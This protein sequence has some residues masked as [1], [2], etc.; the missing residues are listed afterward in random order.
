MSWKLVIAVILALQVTVS[1]CDLPQPDQELVAKYGNVM[2]S[3]HKRL[4]PYFSMIRDFITAP[5][6]EHVLYSEVSLDFF[7]KLS[8]VP[9]IQSVEKVTK[10]VAREVSSL[11]DK[12]RMAAL[13]LY[14]EH[15]RPWA[16][17]YVDRAIAA[18]ISFLDTLR[19]HTNWTL[20]NLPLS[21]IIRL[22]HRPLHFTLGI[23][24]IHNLKEMSGKLVI[25][26]ILAL[27]VT[28]SLCNLPQPGQELKLKYSKVINNFMDRLWQYYEKIGHPIIGPMMDNIFDNNVTSD[29]VE[30]LYKNPYVEAAQDI[31]IGVAIEAF[32][33]ADKTHT[34]ALGLYGE[35]V[36]PWAGPY[37]DRA[38]AAINGLLDKVM[39]VEKQ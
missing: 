31:A 28:V 14:G 39:P 2:D 21:V 18:I 7:E 13:G 38:I 16:G 17:P 4:V 10:G 19:P 29:F 11:I 20:T 35:Y 1:L 34:A 6:I 37:V 9:H 24:S 3:F 25:A 5:L 32:P 26:V 12:S 23:Y 22:P 15:V 36:R 27:Q 30:K 33:L 8:H